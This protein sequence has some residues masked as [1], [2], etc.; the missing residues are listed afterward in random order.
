MLVRGKV[1]ARLCC[2]R[3]CHTGFRIAWNTMPIEKVALASSVVSVGGT[4]ALADKPFLKR[5]W[6]EHGSFLFRDSAPPNRLL[7]FARL[8]YWLCSSL[9]RIMLQYVAHVARWSRFHTE[10]CIP[11]GHYWACRS[12]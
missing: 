9:V 8:L 7:R 11:R 12:S 2:C 10:A 5:L 1:K 6:E 4:K 3:V